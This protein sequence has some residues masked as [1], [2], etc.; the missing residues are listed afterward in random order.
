[1]PSVDCKVWSAECKMCRV[2]SAECKLSRV[3]NR[4]RRVKCKVRS[5]VECKSVQCRGWSVECKV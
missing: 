2:W 3:K 1:M 4:V 5:V